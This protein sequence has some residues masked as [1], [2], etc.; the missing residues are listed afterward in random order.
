MYDHIITQQIKAQSEYI[1]DYKDIYKSSN[2]IR[3]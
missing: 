3:K 2:T 1:Y